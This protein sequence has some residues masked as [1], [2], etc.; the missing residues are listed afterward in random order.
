MKS[1]KKSANL[2]R[3]TA[4]TGTLLIVA[5]V[6][7]S[8]IIFG[9]SRALA[10]D[11]ISAGAEVKVHTHTPTGLTEI[12]VI[13]KHYLTYG[14]FEQDRKEEVDLCRLSSYPNQETKLEFASSSK[15][16]PKLFKKTDTKEV[17]LCPKLN[18]SVPGTNFIDVPK[19]W[20]AEKAIA[21]FCIEKLE[22]PIS[23]ADKY[24][25]EARLK[26]WFADASASSVLA[27][28]HL[29]RILDV[30]LWFEAHFDKTPT[31]SAL[32]R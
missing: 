11:S 2:T 19:G 6:L 14:D 20:S 18:S 16:T 5:T 10:S 24:S 32:G 28:Y 7:T 25:I 17:V 31:V 30:R 27:Y 26:N 8:L 1:I 3:P 13:P 22:V 12:C 23:I 29:S 21:E 15:L 9:N 4:V